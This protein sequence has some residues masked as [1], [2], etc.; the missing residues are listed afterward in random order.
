MDGTYLNFLNM[1]FEEKLHKNTIMRFSHYLPF[2]SHYLPY[3]LLITSFAGMVLA[4]MQIAMHNA[5]LVVPNTSFNGV[6]TLRAMHAEK[7]TTLYGTPTMFIDVLAALRQANAEGG[8]LVD[9]ERVPVDLQS[10]HNGIVAG[11]LCPPDLMSD[12]IEKLHI[13]QMRVC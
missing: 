8:M 7:C 9:G 5:A 2:F 6:A 12:I 3:Q 10:M 13:P 4:N 11:A 1:V